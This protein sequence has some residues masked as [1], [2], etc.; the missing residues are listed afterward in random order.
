[1][2]IA[3]VPIDVV[4]PPGTP[5]RGVVGERQR[6]R[7]R[8]HR[9][10]VP[11]EA[12]QQVGLRGRQV[13]VAGEPP[14]ALE[15]LDVRQRRRRAVDHRDRDGAVE[16]DHRRRPHPQQLV[17]QRQ[18]LRPVGVVVRS[19][20]ERAARRW[21][22]GGRTARGPASERAE[23]EAGRPRRCAR[24]PRPRGPAPPAHQAAG[25]VG[26]GRA[27]GL[28]GQQ[29][30]Q[31]ARGLA[32]AGSSAR[33]IRARSSARP[34]RSSRTSVA[35]GG[36]GVPGRVEQVDDGERGV[37]PRGQLVGRRHRVGDA[38][39]GDLLLGAGDAR[40]HRRLRDEERVRDVRRRH[41]AHEAQRQRD[42]GLAASAGWQQVKISRSRSSGI[43]VR[44]ASG[45]RSRPARAAA[46]ASPPG[47]GR[48][49]A[50]RARCARA[51]VVSQAPGRSGTP[52]RAQVRSACT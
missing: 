27:A 51:T 11:A 12:V 31:Q 44:G 30:R 8:V 35:A 26:A 15:R 25:G 23:D 50:R 4:V 18:D 7:E 49:A 45:S 20:P 48:G 46:A 24:G 28:V 2:L 39:G 38:G 32:L 17:V 29:Q 19:A 43:G 9:L 3:A 33:S 6:G 37:E 36:R 13:A 52:S 42:L 40:R 21:R 22:P 34:V 16:R 5:A 14:V 10:G 47:S 41:A 1:M